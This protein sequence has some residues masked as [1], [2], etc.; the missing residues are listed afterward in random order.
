MIGCFSNKLDFL[1]AEHLLHNVDNR[2]M[3]TEAHPAE[4]K[5]KSVSEKP[6]LIIT[7]GYLWELFDGVSI[8]EDLNREKHIPILIW[9]KKM[10]PP[11]VNA[12]FNLSN[13]Y[14]VKDEGEDGAFLKALARLK[15]LYLIN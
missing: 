1:K 15:S 5:L 4:I 14:F 7:D 9:S 11:I 8:I 2:Y 10:S 3:L 6:E 13:V 12:V